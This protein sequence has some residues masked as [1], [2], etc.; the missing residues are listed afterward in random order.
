VARASGAQLSSEVKAGAGSAGGRS[1]SSSSSAAGSA[2]GGGS[3]GAGRQ[4]KNKALDAMD[5]R[6]WHALREEFAIA[7]RGSKVPNPLRSWYACIS[8]AVAVAVG[9][10]GAGAMERSD[11]S[12]VLWCV[13]CIGLSRP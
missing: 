11:L 1:S 8:A 10:V 7:T 13:F 9:V 4:W 6:D 3:G 5:A 2:S 12:C